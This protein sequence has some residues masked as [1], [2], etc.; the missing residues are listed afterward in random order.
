M[1]T[2]GTRACGSAIP[3]RPTLRV[4]PMRK[5]LKDF[6]RDQTG[7]TAV[8]YGIAAA[9]IAVAIISAAGTLGKNVGNT[10]N[11]TSGNLK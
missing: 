6:W 7:A 11:R 10:F 9:L 8:E 5:L 2:L 1:E 4:C 3:K